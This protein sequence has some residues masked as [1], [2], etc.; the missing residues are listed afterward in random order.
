MVGYLCYVVLV[1]YKW[2][3]NYV[4]YLGAI[5]CLFA[6]KLSENGFSCPTQAARQTPRV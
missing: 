6:R 1:K 3:L 4:L 2:R 5:R